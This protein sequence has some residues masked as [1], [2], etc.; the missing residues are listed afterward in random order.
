MLHRTNILGWLIDFYR[1]AVELTGIPCFL[2]FCSC[3]HYHQ[4]VHKYQPINMRN[5][6]KI[7]R[8]GNHSIGLAHVHLVWIPNRRKKVLVSPVKI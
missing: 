1:D 7:Y 8:H 5:Q 4:V 6:Q 3:L 2:F